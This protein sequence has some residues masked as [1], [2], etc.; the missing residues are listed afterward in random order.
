[1][2]RSPARSTLAAG[3]VAFAAA[4][5]ID[6]WAFRAL[7]IPGIY[8]HDWGRALR[9]VGYLPVWVVAAGALVLQDWTSP[10]GMASPG[11]WRRG[12]LLVGAPT[13]AGI[14]A[15]ALK[16]CI[17][18]E[19]PNL[20]DGAYVFRGW[21]DHP[22]STKDLGLPS[23]HAVVAFGAAT[24]LAHLFPGARAVW[25]SLAGACVFTRVAS[26]AHFVSDVILGGLLGWL[27]AA[28]L[29]RWSERRAEVSQ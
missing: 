23:S 11:R 21:A 10:P 25:Y 28:L 5:L 20:T 4:H 12:L 9:L 3:L 15:E 26:G 24:A 22:W 27:V 16:L 6:R 17:R 14:L 7:A 19:R 29:G 1:M 13:V 18:R 8:D 2:R